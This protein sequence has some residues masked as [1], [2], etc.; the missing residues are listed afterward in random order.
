MLAFGKLQ[1]IAGNECPHRKTA[2]N[3]FCKRHDI[4]LHLRM[5]DR[6]PF[7]GPAHT[8]L[9]FIDKILSRGNSQEPEVLFRAF[10]GREPDTKALLVRSG[11]AA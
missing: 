1:P 4:R 11:L 7:S 10:M 5:L 3:S 2:C 8:G 6:Q 9:D